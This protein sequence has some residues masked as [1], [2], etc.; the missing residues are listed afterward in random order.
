[1]STSE[2]RVVAA[3]RASLTENERLRRHNDELVRTATEPI[4][5]IGM[6]CRFPGDVTT[7]EQLWELVAAGADAVTPFPADRGWDT[8]GDASTATTHQ[9]GF[10][11]TAADFDAGFFGVSPREALA[12]DPQQRLILETSWEALE[13]AGLAPT[14]VRGSRT[15]VYVGCSNQNYGAVSGDDLPDGIGGHLLTGNA[16]SVVSGRV[17]Y[18]LGLEGP[19]VTVDT[20][21]SS[22]LV[23]LHLAVQA[24]RAGECDLAL[25]GGVTVMS[26]PDV[27]TEFARQGGLAGDGRCKAFADAADGTGWGEGAGVL[28][29]ER[30][31]DARRR[32]HRVLAVVRGSAVNQDGASNG[33]TAP[34]GPAQQRVIRAALAGAGVSASEVDVVEAHGTGTRLGDPIEAQALLATYGQ[35]RDA[36][37]PLWLGSVKSNVGHT[38]A[39][40]GV[41]GVI[42][43]VEALRHG[44][45]PATLHVDAPSSQVDWASGS[46]RL[47][48]EQQPWPDTGRP[49]VAGVSAFGVSGTNAHV[50]LE[51]SPLPESPGEPLAAPAD[52]APLVWPLSGRTEDALRAQARALAAFADRDPEAVPSR[53]ALALATT[54]THFEHRA[55]VVT[56]DPTRLTEALNGLADSVTSA[57]TMV[58]QDRGESRQAFLFSGQGAQR[59]GMGRELYDAFP[60]FADAFDAVCAYVGSG[61]RDVVFGGD[62]ERLGRTQWTQPALFAV[63]VALFR[64]VESLGVR[65]DFVIGHSVG[66]IAAAHV[67]GVLSLEDACAL[68]VAR[69]RLMQELPSGGAMV[70]VEAAEDEVVP[71]LDVSLVSVAAV[72]GPRSVVIAGVEAAVTE[73]AEKLKVRGRRTSR[74][75]VSHAFHSPLMEPML[76][77]FREVAERITY[78]T[79]A[80]PVV[81]NVTGRLATDGD[82]TSAEYWVR[83]VRQAVRFA[84]GV[85][86][87]AAEGVTRFLEIGPDGTLTALARTVLGDVDDAL[88][89]PL[90]RKDVSEHMAVL[91]AMARFH[92]DG[93]EVD[94]SVLLG[95][96]DGAPAVDLP[97]Y[98]FQRQRY[99]LAPNQS[100]PG[101]PAG[102]AHASAVID[103]AFWAAVECEDLPALAADLD[104]AP[105][106]LGPV[107]PALSKWYRQRQ[108]QA[109]VDALR[110][111]VS[112]KPL[113]RD[114]EITPAAGASRTGNWTV[115]V[116]ADLDVASRATVNSLVAGFRKQGLTPR[117]VETDLADPEALR[118]AFGE[119]GASDGT[120]A[121]DGILSLLSLDAS[122]DPVVGTL[123]ALRALAESEP[124]GTRLWVLTHGAVAVGSPD[125]VTRTSHSAVWGLGRVAALEHP[126]IWGGL[127]DLPAQVDDRVSARLAV[128]LTRLGPDEDQLAIRTHGIFGRRLSQAA[129]LPQLTADGW[130]PRGTVLITG[131][132]GALGAHVARWAVT[133][134]ARDLLLVSRSGEAAPG[135][136]ELRAELQEAGAQVTLAAL[137]VSERDDLAALLAEHPVDAVFHTAGVLDDGTL[138]ATDAGRVERVMGPKATAALLLD[139]LTRDRDLSAFVLF[140]SLAGTLGSPGQ[141]AY[142]AANAVLDALAERRRGE[143]LP[144]TSIAWGPWAG[145]GMASDSGGRRRGQGAVTA[146]APGFALSALGAALDGDITTQLVVDADWNRFIPAFTTTRPS[147]LLTPMTPP[148]AAGPAPG[149]SAHTGAAGDDLRSRAASLSREAGQRLVLDEVQKLA[150]MMLGHTGPGQ[151]G[152]ERAFRDLGVDS[153]IAVELR[154]VLA[155]AT[156]VALPTTVVFDHPTPR[157]LAEFLYGELFGADGAAAAVSAVAAVAVPD[158]PVAIVGMACRFPGDVESP[159]DLWDMLVDGRDGIADFPTDRGWAA[160]EPVYDRYA[161]GDGGTTE[162]VRR[163]GFLSGVVGFD[164]EFFG[165]SPREALAMDPQQRLLLEVC[166]EA[167]ERAGVDPRS[168][169]GSRVGVFAGTNGQDYPALLSVSEGDFGGYVGTGNAASVVSGRVSYVLGLEG[170]AVT[171]D[172]ACSS[173]LVALHLAVQ[174]LRSGECDLALAGGVTV[175]ST[176]GAF[177]EFSRQGGLA[178]DGRCKAFADAADGTGWGEGAGVLLVERLSDA[179]RHGHRVLA[180]VRGSAVNQDGASNGLSA[181]NGPA[182]QRVIRAALAGAGVSASEVDVVEAHGTGTRLGDPIE[183]QA[184]L[185]TYGQGRDADRPLWL[186]S[187]KSNVGHT[188]AAAGVAGVIKMV[189]ALRHGVL[190]ATLHADEPSSHVDWSSGGVELLTQARQWPESVERARRA[191]VSSFGLSGTNAHVILEEAPADPAP[192]ESG[193]GDGAVLPWLVSARSAE[194]QRAQAGRLLTVVRKRHDSASVGL[195]RALASTRTSFEQRAVVLAATQEEFVEELQALHLG[196]TGLRTVTGVTREGGRTA[197]LFS[198]QGAQRPGMGRELYE[199]FPVFADAFD[200]VCAYVGSGLRDVVFGGDGERLGRTEWTQPALF[201]VEVAL[202][203]LVE[204][205]GVRPDFVIGHSVG[206]IAAAH[207]AGVLSLEDACALVTARGRLM[208]ELPSG[209]AMVAV[210]A[211]EDEVV[212]L[213]DASLVSV[214]AVNG[215]RSAVI[216][217]VEAAVTEVAEKL[218]VR[219]RRTSRL[220]VSHAFHSP[221]MEPMLD[222]FREVAERIT[223]GTPALPVVS[224]V[225][226]RLATDGDLTS[227]EYW[228]RHVRQAVR[229]AD[230]VSA[231]AAEGVTRFLE[232]GPD[233]TLTALARTVLGD[234]DDA[235]FVPLLRKD[236]SEHMAVLR[237]MARFHVDGGEVDW[238]VL[239]GSGDGA[240][241]VDLPTYP[242][243]RQRYW[244]TVTAQGAAPTYPSLSQADVSFW[245]VV[246]EGAPELADTLGVS[247]EAMNAVLPAL[248]ALRREQLERAE[249]EGWCYRVDWEPVVVPD[250]KPVTGRWLLLQMPDD[251]PLAGLEQFIPGLERL[252]CD[253]LDRKGLARL[254]EQAVEGE[255]PAGVLSC[256]SLPSPGDGRP[257]SEAG[258]AVENVM[259]LV[260]ALGDAGAAA[261][262]WVVTHAGFGPG[263]APDEPAQ[264]AV[265]GF[266]RV[267]ALECPD[268]WGGLVDVPP[269]PARDELGSLAS[270]LSHAREDQVSV[271]GAATYARRL[272]PAPLPASAPTAT[273]DADHRIPQR[274]LVTGGTGAL[275]VRV[276][277]WFAGRGTTQLVLTSRSGPDAPGVADTVA[278]LRAAG[279]ERVEVVACDV[280]DRLQVA[281]LLDAHPVDGIAHAAGILDVDPI[282]TTTPDDMDRVLG[283]K[284]WGAVYLD[285]LTRGWD[286][287]AFVVFS[288][289]AG[290]WGSGGQGAYAAAN[291]WA[292]AVVEARC[293]RGLVGASVGWGPWSGGGMVSDVGAVELGRRGLRVMDPGCA[294]VGLGSV[295]EGGGGAVVVADV[296]WE[297]FVPAFTSRR[298]SPLLTSL[299]HAAEALAALDRPGP[300]TPHEAH[301]SGGGLPALV[302]HLA[303]LSPQGR[304]TALLDHVRR[305]AARALGYAE[306]TAVAPDRAFRDMG[307]DSL[308]A[309]EL[310]NALLTDTGLRLPAT[311]V[312]D[313][314]TPAVLARYLDGALAGETGSVT[315]MLAEVES[316]IARIMKTDPDQDIRTLLGT[317]LRAFL[318]EMEDTGAVDGDYAGGPALGARLD[319]ASDEELFDLISRELEQ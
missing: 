149:G 227:A 88:F 250:E 47:L 90:L 268:R 310:R 38:Q 107:V 245:A 254:L 280:A 134:G 83:H 262:L 148:P 103:D 187:V 242:F 120:R 138:L 222:A 139:E 29:V 260:Q 60:V 10:V 284:G 181:P 78:G 94:W 2:E 230:G 128:A 23:A 99:W 249:V 140:S 66:E 87:L 27:F 264:A 228:V 214:A 172:T 297:R 113:T 197:F 229:F 263:R 74:L 75:R 7:P 19:A 164:A 137:D 301:G 216:A 308:T 154:N 111:E 89:V 255:E 44:V 163:G 31:S 306:T 108:D 314:P 115:L 311:L 117:V 33:L 272:R 147:A 256:L 212:P 100:A 294:L 307:F 36:D 270:V 291:A 151:V 24:L 101:V 11:T 167:V 286:L 161:Q 247:Q 174:S 92:V 184:L 267:A 290:V 274:L 177:V 159:E 146:L 299:P 157:V 251:V 318:S 258:R 271:R 43:M 141:G 208:Q 182:Q 48:T 226:G 40:A 305:A 55:V 275:G 252:T 176:P 17:S 170:P 28:L 53:T 69:G 240:P 169:R 204:S 210:E 209:G 41:A 57:D 26:T 218:K 304:T 173:S 259:A 207:V 233:G 129:P 125:R 235:L 61:L 45:V 224:N 206:E 243:Q 98:P 124:F 56:D 273:R 289:V 119:I 3:L 84:D 152:A 106:I 67:A 63:E 219:G 18:V 118:L 282:D 190:P 59:P 142:A 114:D 288:S 309:V 317:R 62:G 191:G 39:A 281:A 77:A 244:P 205:L 135:V 122:A 194:A 72:N 303:T 5:I 15:G 13:H 64:L 32:G 110:Y 223:Y 49:R 296:E 300:G 253:A 46:V 220:R 86:A 76:D 109:M 319:D 42:K 276:A 96:G 127:I 217:G 257:A 192:E 165:V 293:G 71:L 51:Q 183:A 203:R 193:T 81:S 215:P 302:E 234:V 315:T 155:A 131:G 189:E 25:A 80:L 4:A 236:V 79:P 150:A 295:L 104:L 225:T 298:P 14:S 54:R 278:R 199:A 221:L 232:I 85:S 9:G 116:P 37:R 105:D 178:G 213:L 20:A 239:L 160:I 162:F 166:W 196:E 145:D 133:R 186:G 6:A 313:Y 188:Q 52:S 34:N 35:G 180:V 285:E 171:V 21:C 95:S 200:A 1:M 70:A 279:A 287:D 156:G 248:T 312:F 158:E 132:T 246:E 153:L 130:E 65:P 292:D 112:W 202:F 231:L 68:V 82:L 30:L 93:G 58:G 238:S 175:M 91:R 211:A 265:W 283:A 121:P 201:A 185:A 179:R 316:S 50:I 144:A 195:A 123:A 143:G 198:G 102:P 126:D 261:P 8:T 12:M 16:A 136:A 269:H 241:A 237:A 168:L 73:V 97:T 266:G 22:S 277:E